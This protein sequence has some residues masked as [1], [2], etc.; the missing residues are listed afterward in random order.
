M[1]RLIVITAVLVL[2]TAALALL[3]LM[4]AWDNY[5]DEVTAKAEAITGRT[6]VIDGRIDLNLLPRPTLSLART[7][8]SSGPDA[9]DRMR[10]EIDRLDLALK[11]LPLLGGRL[12]VEEVRLVRPVLQGEA[13]AD[14]PQL[15]EL[16]GAVAWLPLTADGPSRI[17]VVDGRAMLSEPALGGIS[18][19][20]EVNIE[21]TISDSGSAIELDGTFASNRQPFHVDARLGRLTDEGSSTLRLQLVADS[22]AQEGAGTIG[23]GGVVWWRS[24]TPRLRGE[25]DFTGD[26]ARSAIGR[27]GAALGQHVMP[28]PAWL[29]TPFRL[30]GP[31]ALQEDRL[32]LSEV[33]LALDGVE[34]SG[35]LMLTLNAQPEIDLA[36]EAARLALPAELASGDAFAEVAPLGAMASSLRGQIDLSV[37]TL[38]YRG[39]AL[40]RLRASLH[41]TGDGAAVVRDARAILPGQTDVSFSGRLGEIAGDPRLHGEI[42]AVTRNL[43]G[44]LAWLDL[45]P[46]EVAEGRLNSLSLASQLSIASGAWRFDGIQLRIDA[47]RA[48]GAVTVEPAPRP[49]VTATIELDRFD[50]DAYWPDETPVALLARLAQ[51]FQALDAA[52]DA[53]LARLTWAGVQLLDVTFAGQAVDRHL[54]IDQLTVGDFAEA[55]AR[56]AGEVDLAA[57]RFDLAADAKGVQAARLLRRLGWEPAALLTRLQPLSIE[58]VASGSV[59]AA[60]IELELTDD[61]GRIMLAG[62]LGLIEQGP[63]Y[64]LEVTA[65]H[66]DYQSLLRDLGAYPRGAPGSAAP[67]TI[68]GR[69][70]HE[71]DGASLVAGTARFGVTSLTGRVAWQGGQPRPSLTARISVG[72]PTT[73]V[74]A[75]LL[76]LSGLRLEWPTGSE[77]MG[78]WSERPLAVDLID[79]FDGEVILS[80]K[81]GL[82][83]PGFELSGRFEQGKLMLDHFA[84][85]LW[86]GQLS[87][88]L[89]L[90]ARRPLPYLTASLDLSGFDPRALAGWLGM[91]PVVSGPADLRLE[92]TAAGRTVRDLVGS[93]IGDI[94]ITAHEGATLRSLPPGFPIA[95]EPA[96]PDEA[97]PD[98]AGLAATLPL[99]RGVVLAPPMMLAVN[100]AQ[101][102][103]E[104]AIDLYLWA[105]DLT[106]RAA[107]AGPELRVVGPLDRPQIRLQPDASAP[108]AP[109]EAS[110]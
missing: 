33:G 45:S 70:E 89:T 86:G 77:V 11:P 44:A 39:E 34:L 83:G 41:L 43:R 31:V 52:I 12:D 21:L 5:R 55:E 53:R 62:E 101:V 84:T 98:L 13:A 23:F 103:L 69:L 99:K 27:L 87:G 58:G 85:A 67:L 110:P 54:T 60:Q 36:L 106:L 4:F 24:E 47:S 68:A 18:R 102:Q 100:G 91:V 25:L 74:L 81:G 63:R 1:R 97:A 61:A 50:V 49:R 95:S 29:A 64:Q 2:L 88:E 10:L 14:G 93:L 42:A 59:E 79:R 107:G 48:T 66:P 56:V 104:G 105:M 40:R 22:E 72:E 96:A 109:D 90:E 35:R 6:V 108:D 15:P 17:S 46:G 32:D 28:M 8:V 94:E 3:P 16:V 73:P 51:P 20:D 80:G 65:D 57:G 76:D 78:R 38:E 92:A 82:A 9:A 75:A 37:G 19:L 7:T 26:D 30:T 71:P